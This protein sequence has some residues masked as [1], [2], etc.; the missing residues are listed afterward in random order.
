MITIT[1]ITITIT[2]HNSQLFLAR[3]PTAGLASPADMRLL[4][5]IIE[6]LSRHF[7]MEHYHWHPQV[8]VVIYKLWN[9]VRPQADPQGPE[10][11]IGAPQRAILSFA[12][13]ADRPCL[14]GKH[15]PVSGPMEFAFDSESLLCR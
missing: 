15:R 2:I 4:F 9:T 6:T 1:I 5:L 8:P 10:A 11:P 12:Q 13:M 7:R 3:I 14:L